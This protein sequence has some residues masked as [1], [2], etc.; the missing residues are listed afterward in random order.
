M[1]DDRTKEQKIESFCAMYKVALMRD[2]KHV[3]GFRFNCPTN[4]REF[5]L[6]ATDPTKLF[7]L[8]EQK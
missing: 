1:K 2:W 4:Q 7:I 5:D 3:H 8:E 6:S